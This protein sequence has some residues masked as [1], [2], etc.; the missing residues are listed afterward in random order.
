MLR[1]RTQVFPAPIAALQGDHDMREHLLHDLAWARRGR[2]PS[3]P[4]RQTRRC[5]FA[6]MAER[7]R[8]AHEVAGA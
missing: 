8:E 4:G 7:I 1:T 6:P 5:G 2:L 3:V